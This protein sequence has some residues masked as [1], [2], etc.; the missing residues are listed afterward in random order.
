MNYTHEQ[1]DV[2]LKIVPH[3]VLKACYTIHYLTSI[4]IW[5]PLPECHSRPFMGELDA[6]QWIKQNIDE[7]E[8]V[9]IK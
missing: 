6:L 8:S 4:G 5:S 7:Y 9:T 2:K 3:D 1:P